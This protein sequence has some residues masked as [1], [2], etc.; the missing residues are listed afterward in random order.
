MIH[1]A[2]SRQARIKGVCAT[3]ALLVSV[4]FYGGVI[5]GQKRASCSK[6]PITKLI[7]R[8]ACSGLM[9]TSL[10]QVVNKLAASCEL[11]AGLMQVVLST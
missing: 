8:N 3:M 6:F 1:T 9:I 4:L 10:L 2:P 5:H 7:S 11:H